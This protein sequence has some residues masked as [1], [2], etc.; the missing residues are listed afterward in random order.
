M[1]L[2]GNFGGAAAK[3]RF[4]LVP[5]LPLHYAHRDNQPR[6]LGKILH[7]QHDSFGELEPR[8]PDALRGLRCCG[9][10]EDRAAFNRQLPAGLE[11]LVQHDACQPTASGR[12][13]AQLTSALP[14]LEHRLLANVFGR[15]WI[16]KDAVCQSKKQAGMLPDLIR[17][18]RSKIIFIECASEHLW[19]PSSSRL[20]IQ[21]ARRGNIF[22]DFLGCLD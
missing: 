2:P 18:E 13:I 17:Q 4:D 10:L 3:N 22:Q 9:T 19:R 15:R 5:A 14:C 7:R 11:A 1:Q 6:G 16:A 8:S 21:D 12:F 20:C